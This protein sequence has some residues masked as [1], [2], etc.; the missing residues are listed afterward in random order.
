MLF[1]SM[2]SATLS[3]GGRQGFRHFQERLGFT[4]SETLLLGSPFN[5]RE[6]V[7]LHLFRRMPDPSSEPQKY[8]E[9]VV[10]KRSS[11]SCAALESSTLRSMRSV[12]RSKT[13]L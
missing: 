10:A 9:A 8:E 4:S 12:P 2:T 11:T 7:E 5:Y 3:T 1:R 13:C 6:Q